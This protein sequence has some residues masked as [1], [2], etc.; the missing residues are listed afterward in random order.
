NVS[1]LTIDKDTRRHEELRRIRIERLT[2]DG[3]IRGIEHALFPDLK[4]E[5]ASVVGVFLHHSGRSA[6]YPD[7]VVFVDMTAVEARFEK[8]GIAPRIDYIALRI[9]LNN[10]RSHASRVQVHVQHILTIENEHVVLAIDAD[11]AQPS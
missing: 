8:L 10:K 6:S 9:N 2:L 4:Q 1:V 7:V 3:T 5:L 11:A